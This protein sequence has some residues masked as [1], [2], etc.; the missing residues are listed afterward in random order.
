MVRRVIK[1]STVNESANATQTRVAKPSDLGKIKVGDTVYHTDFK[2][3]LTVTE[4]HKHNSN[5]MKNFGIEGLRVKASD[6]NSYDLWYDTET[7]RVEG[8]IGEG[9]HKLRI[10]INESSAMNES[11][12]IGKM[13]ESIG[14]TQ[15]DWKKVRPEEYDEGQVEGY[16]KNFDDAAKALKCKAQD[17]V[18]ITED[19]GEAYNYVK[20][21]SAEVDYYDE[22]EDTMYSD[23]ADDKSYATNHVDENIDLISMD[24]LPR[25]HEFELSEDDVNA[26]TD[27]FK[28]NNLFI[29][30]LHFNKTDKQIEFDIINGDWKHEHLFAQSLIRDYF[31]SQNKIVYI[32][33]CEIGN[34]DSDCYSAH[35]ELTP[36][37][38]IKTP[39]NE[40][41]R[42]AKADQKISSAKTSI[43]SNKLPAIYNMVKFNKGDLVLDYGGG[44]FDNGIEFLKDKGATGLVYDP[45]N[46]DKDYNKETLKTISDNGGADVVL[47]SNV[48]N[49]IAEEPA[50]IAALKN[51][52]KLLKSGGNFYCTVYEGNRSGTGKETKSGYQL[53]TKTAD[54]LDEVKTVFKDAAIKGKLISASK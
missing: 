25:E 39:K 20:N 14:M 47:L 1:E 12:K 11:A 41:V 26:L 53:N 10:P 5:Y 24:I 43:N 15:S 22:L 4:I 29:D 51:C 45:Y 16:I 23:Y 36:N 3:P 54:Y 37:K 13:N 7:L 28:E 6:G 44:K 40:S 21:I 46:R 52:K 31:E 32:D 18:N 9:I 2:G 42:L 19:D 49:V 8:R 50:R 17:L 30:E 27:I 48:L 34:S 33:S 38:L 35:Y